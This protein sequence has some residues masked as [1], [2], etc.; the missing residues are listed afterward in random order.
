MFYREGLLVPRP[1]P[2]LEDHP[3]SAVHDCL[4]NLFTATLHK[5]GRYS[6]RN[7]RTRHAVVT[8]THC[9]WQNVL[10]F[11]ITY[12]LHSVTAGRIRIAQACSSVASSAFGPVRV[13]GLP[14]NFVWGGVQQIQ[15]RTEDRQNGYPGAIAP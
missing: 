5:G 6:I 8:G 11:R 15:L 12:V 3:L 9:T 10:T 2:K 7:L 4:F 1:T 14:R 13:S